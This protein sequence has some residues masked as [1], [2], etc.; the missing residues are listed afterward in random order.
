[1]AGVSFDAQAA[2]PWIVFAGILVAGLVALRF[3]T[4]YFGRKWAEI[5]TA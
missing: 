5:K 2:A 3:A 1:V 4:R